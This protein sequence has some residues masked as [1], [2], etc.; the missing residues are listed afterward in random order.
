MLNLGETLGASGLAAIGLFSAAAAF[1]LGYSR[2]QAHQVS[3]LSDYRLLLAHIHRI[4]ADAADEAEFLRSV[5]A[6]TVEHA[7]VDLTWIGRPGADGVFVYLA[8]AGPQRAYLDDIVIAADPQRPE[9]Q[10]TSGRAWRDARAYFNTAFGRNPSLAPWAARAARFGLRTSAAIPVLL[11]GEPWAVF[12]LY[13]TDLYPFD[14]T[15]V[16]L[17]DDLAAAIAAGLSRIRLLRDEHAAQSLNS[18]LLENM[19]AGIQVVR[20]PQRWIERAN[21]R[22]LDMLGVR[23][24]D[25]LRATSARHHYDP[26][27]VE[28]LGALTARVLRDGNGALRDVVLRREDGQKVWMDVSGRRVELDD[29]AARIVWTHVDVTE[30][31]E[32]EQRLRRLGAM[33]E[34]LLDNTI[35]GIDLVQYP[36]RRVIEANAALVHIM[37]YES[38]E[39]LLGMDARK[40]YPNPEVSQRMAQLAEKVLREGSGELGNVQVRRRDGS[41]ARLDLH[42]KRLQSEDTANPVIVWTSVDATRKYELEAELHRQAHYDELTDLPNRRALRE[43][44][45]G[46]ILRAQ[47]GGGALAVGVLDLDDFKPVNDRYGHV[48][49]DQLLRDIVLRLRGAL[50]PGDMLARIG[51]DEFVLLLDDLPAR[52]EQPGLDTRLHPMHLAMQQALP[53]GDQDSVR[54][55]MSMGLALYPHDATEAD[56][57]LR[58][59]DAAMYQVKARKATRASWWQR[60]GTQVPAADDDD[61]IDPFGAGAAQLLESFQ[62]QMREVTRQ[63]AAEF[64][65]RVLGMPGAQGI[66]D[67]LP[68]VEREQLKRKLAEH[69]LQGL[70]PAARADECERRAL[71][72]GQTHALVGLSAGTVSRTLN[73]YRSMLRDRVQ[74]LSL[75]RR[76]RTRVMQVANARMQLELQCELTRMQEVYDSYN[77]HLARAL[78]DSTTTWASLVRGELDALC[79]LAGLRAVFVMRL[80]PDGRFFAEFSAGDGMRMLDRA[81]QDPQLQPNLDS[82]QPCGQGLVAQAWRTGEIQRSDAALLDARLHSWLPALRDAAVQSAVALPIKDARNSFVLALYGAYPH[83]FASGWACTFIASLRTRWERVAQASRSVFTP[84]LWQEAAEYRRL[85]HSG[86]LDMH[87]QPVLDTQTGR[88]HKVEML[89][90]LRDADQRMIPPARFLPAFDDTDTH[91]LFRL[92]LEQTLQAQERWRARGLALEVSLNVAPATLLHADMVHWVDQALRR[93]GSPPASLTLEILESQEFLDERQAQAV[94]RLAALGVKLAIDDLGAGY[95]SLKRLVN[96]PFD[97]VKIDQALLRELNADPAK[98][99]GLVSAII[100]IGEDLGRTVV[101][102]GV[103]DAPALEA[104]MIIGARHVQGYAVARPMPLADIDAWLGGFACPRPL[105]GALQSLLGAFAWHWVHLRRELPG[106]PE[107]AAPRLDPLR[108]YLRRCH[109]QDTELLDAVQ[110]CAEL[111]GPREAACREVLQLLQLRLRGAPQAARAA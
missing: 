87:A 66:L 78:P 46:S 90:R 91:T 73:E 75:S 68:L 14:P 43:R 7:K 49:G 97:V 29:G 76:E 69:L 80:S 89:A 22:M 55:G 5:C 19:A 107:F 82:R 25:E 85:L 11:D 59:A 33:R 72:V 104:M 102:E 63:Y 95:S 45:R 28:R 20:Y 67:C 36:E 93:H 64:D 30:R 48:V 18:A 51:G 27:T 12:T 44:L 110:R 15:L 105:D 83:Q 1:G 58:E 65:R 109:A 71:H 98:V 84:L 103:E 52:I 70:S 94:H 53:V 24:I 6:L 41:L 34:A 96:L 50:H 42:G 99:L 81:L 32:Q 35:V 79:R 100:R 17:V 74:T 26:S 8:S 54:I 62:E 57:L 77:E 10:G 39:Q 61:E 37:G 9:G 106:G 111:V 38:R 16:A 2:R 4:A 86:G 40:L 108:E 23:D 88:V 56:A 3:R 31:R 60:A 13:S 47:A 92:G 101:V 21:A